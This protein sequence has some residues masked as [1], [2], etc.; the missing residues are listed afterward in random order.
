MIF[1]GVLVKNALNTFIVHPS[2]TLSGPGNIDPPPQYFGMLPSTNNI[3]QGPK[4][5]RL[6]YIMQEIGWRLHLNKELFNPIRPAQYFPPL[7]ILA[8]SQAQTTFISKDLN[9]PDYSYIIEEPGW[10]LHLNE[11]LSSEYLTWQT[12][13]G[14]LNSGNDRNTH[15]Q[16]FFFF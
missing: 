16:F 12:E 1:A 9:M 4:S 6:F 5:V 8:C 15:T 7:N 3:S 2:G 10:R 14:S 11:E 13:P